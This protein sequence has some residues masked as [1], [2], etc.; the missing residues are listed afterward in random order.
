MVGIPSLKMVNLGLVHPSCARQDPCCRKQNGLPLDAT[1][2]THLGYPLAVTSILGRRVHT[3]GYI[4]IYV[5]THTHCIYIYMYCMCVYIYI[6][7]II[8]QNIQTQQMHKL[9]L[10]THIYIYNTNKKHNSL[11]IYIHIHAPMMMKSSPKW[12]PNWM[13][14]GTS[15]T[16]SFETT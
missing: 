12:G 9:S 13:A 4:Y 3:Y 5:Y 8:T 2:I 14:F 10:Y 7:I 6:F 1:R 15:W 16:I 11:S